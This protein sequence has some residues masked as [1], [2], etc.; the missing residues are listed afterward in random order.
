MNDAMGKR[1]LLVDDDEA[2]RNVIAMMLES[3]GA[4]VIKAECAADALELCHAETFDLVITDYNMPRM[5]G[6][7]LAAEIKL[8]NPFQR[9]FLMSGFAETTFQNSAFTSS[10]DG[11][12]PKPCDLDQLIDAL[13][14][15][16]PP[17][18]DR[19]RIAA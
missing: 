16:A 9:V 15:K 13:N 2:V 4:V 10:M 14:G 12:L 18:P 7:Q 3:V 17:T 6:D 5:Q 1:V 19:S 11:F 8:L